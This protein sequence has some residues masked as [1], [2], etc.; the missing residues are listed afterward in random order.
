MEKKHK[1]EELGNL[2]LEKETINLTDIVGVL[3]ERPGGMNETMKE[4]LSEQ[5]ELKAKEDKL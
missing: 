5:L 1:I 4:Y 2:L 3:G